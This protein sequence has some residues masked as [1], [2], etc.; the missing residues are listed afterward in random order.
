MSHSTQGVSPVVAF[1]TASRGVWPVEDR[2]AQTVSVRVRESVGT[3]GGH[4]GTRISIKTIGFRMF[5]LRSKGSPRGQVN[6]PRYGIEGVV[7]MPE[8]MRKAI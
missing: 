6:V 3:L 1:A 4:C 5:H 2:G 8:D 7:A